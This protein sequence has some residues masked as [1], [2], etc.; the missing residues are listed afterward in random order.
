[1]RLAAKTYDPT[2]TSHALMSYWVIKC[3]DHT[4]YLASLFT[5]SEEHRYFQAEVLGNWLRTPSLND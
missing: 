5:Y 3:I 1:M 2:R 4:D